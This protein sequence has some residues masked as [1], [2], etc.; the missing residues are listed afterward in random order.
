MGIIN[1]ILTWVMKKR[2][3]QIGLFI[4]YPYEVQEEIFRKLIQTASQTEFGRQYKF[5]EITTYNQ[6]CSRVP[7]HSYED[8]YPYIN[9]LMR[10]EQNV[11]WPSEI[12]WFS[13][14]SGTTNAR[15]K[16]IPVSQ[17]ALEDCHFKGG[18]DL[19]SIYVNNFPETKL[20]DGK[21]LAVGGSH[22]INEF[23]PTAT[24]YYGDVSAVIMQNLPPWAQFIRTPSLETALMNNWEEKIVRMA[25]EA[26]LDNVTHVAGVPTWTILLLQKILEIKGKSNITEVWPNLEVFFHGAVSFKPYKGLFQS[27]IPTTSMNYWETYNASEGF[28]G[29]QDRSN[30]EDLLLML[31]YG[32]FYEFIPMDEIEKENPKTVTLDGVELNKNYALVITTNAGLW[33]L[34]R[35]GRSRSPSARAGS[36]GSGSR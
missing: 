5:G 13:K 12:K 17:E 6:F 16:F 27:I 2:I 23:D 33:G 22:Q 14:S 9:R 1:S 15:S 24:S 30:K 19:L 3:H 32:I 20:F 7:I 36:R 29:I 18:K 25:N 26:T 35:G 10:G 28:F 8:I 4:K 34:A 11:L 21:G 31:D